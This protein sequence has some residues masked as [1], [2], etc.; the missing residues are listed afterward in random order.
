MECEGEAGNAALAAAWN[1]ANIA[2]LEGC[3]SD[4]CGDVEVTSDFN[5]IQQYDPACGFTGSLT[6]TYTITDDCG[7]DVTKQATLTIVDTTDP[8]VSCDPDDRTVECDGEAGNAALA[9]A[10]NAANIAKLEGCSSDICGDVEVTS[11]FDYDQLLDPA[12]GF[13]GSLTVTY[14]ITDDCG[15]DLTKQATFTIEDTTDPEVTCDPDDRTVECDGEAG[16]A[17]LA[18]AWNTANIAKLEACSSDICGDVEVTSDFNFN[19][20]YDPACGFTGSLTVTYTITD[21]CGNDVTKQATFTIEDTTDPVV[22][23]DP[24]DRTVECDGEA[25]NAALAAAWNAANIAKLEAC[26]SD[27]CGDVEVT[28]NF[29]YN[30]LLDPACGFTGSL[31]VTYTITDDC[32]NDVT[33]QA[34]FTIE[35]TTD[36]VVSCDPDDRTVECEGEA[37]NAAL[38]AAWNAANIAKLEAC[39]SDIC[40]DVEVTSNF[41][42]NQL[43]DPACGF[44]GSLTVTYTITDDCGNDVT[45]QATFTIVDTTDPVVSCDPD[46]RTAECEGQAGN[47]AL[48]AAWNAANIAKLEACSSDICGDVEVTSDFNFSQQYDPACGF[49]GS[50]TVTYT[51]TDD[52]GNDVTKQATFTIIDTT[53]PVVSC[54]P[55]DRTV[56]C[57]G[58][59]GNAALA[60]AWNAANIAKLEACSSDICGDVEVTSDFNFS[61]QYDPACGFTGSLTVTYTITDDCGND[62]TKQATFTIEDTTDPVVSCDPDDRTVECEGETGNA[63]L[64]A[65]W[66]AA[67]I[68]KLEACSSDICGDVE[69]TSNFNYNQLLDPACGFTGSLTVTYTITDDCGNDV[70][71]QATFTIVDTTDPVVSCDPDDRTAECEGEAGNAALAAAWNAANI[72]K[73]E[74]CSS[75]ICGDVEVTSNFNFSQQYDPACGFTGSLTVTYTITDDCGNDVTKQAT[76]TIVDTTDPVV[77]CDPDDRTAECEGE[78]GNAALAAAWNAANIAK[79]EACSSD[80]CGDVEV[81]SNF[82]FSQQYD[83]ACGFTGS[84]TVTYTITD[85]CGNDVTKQATFTI[86]DT[87]DPVVSCD[88]DD[89]TV[90][91]DGETGN[92]ALAAAWNAANIAK[93]EGCSSDRCG[94]VEVTSNFDFNQQYDPACGFTGSLTVTYTITDDC[95]NDVTKQATFTIEDTTDPVVSCDPDD[96]TA[97]CEGEAGNAALAATWNAANIAKLEACSSD[98]CGD[99]EVT[100]NFNY[101][102]LL[103]PACGFTGSLTVT[104]TI[105]DDCGNDVTKQATFTIVDTT[106][107]VVNCDP[108][109]RTVECEGEA[110]NAAL[111]AAWNAANI[112]KLEAMLIR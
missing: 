96:R 97:E 74:S 108:D 71:K 91:C 5:F 93:L 83:P 89:R 19:Q 107:P 12:C 78:A 44:T 65:A 7:N 73:L 38:A 101:N 54:D 2:K 68:A 61:Q 43:L 70:S 69:V 112:A 80:R 13:T 99:V 52:C 18:A 67:N 79:L 24:D 45:K 46:D 11:N 86:V 8:V 82:N 64:A 76:F 25:G 85:D 22:S 100:S 72:A 84:L 95:G 33:R 29:N 37:G 94:D 111:A 28:S 39:S 59:S 75:D 17:A 66:N 77:S 98:I 6:V 40:G 20:Q 62:V 60:A 10:W 41:N 26:S 50:L 51:I 3:S 49:T 103:D 81:T 14:T 1:A 58:E 27:I 34:T 87:T 92:A 48:A 55:D 102:Q 53:D 30:Q 56:E 109:D 16:N 42:Y 35:D 110:G 31:T 4:I 32:G 105:T 104:Y 15:N 47:A 23:C 63:A 36:P 88:P 9:A 106:D 57:D 90:E 21:D